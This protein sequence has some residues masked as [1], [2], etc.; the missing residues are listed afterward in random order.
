MAYC[1]CCVFNRRRTLRRP[2]YI[3]TAAVTGSVTLPGAWSGPCCASF[4][5]NRREPPSI[6]VQQHACPVVVILAVAAG[7]SKAGIHEPAQYRPQYH[8]AQYRPH[9]YPAGSR[10]GLLMPMEMAPTSFESMMSHQPRQYTHRPTPTALLPPP[11]R[12][13]LPLALP[14]CPSRLPPPRLSHQ[15]PPALPKGEASRGE[16]FISFHFCKSKPPKTPCSYRHQKHLA[17][18]ATMSTSTSTTFVD[19][20]GNQTPL[21]HVRSSQDGRSATCDGTLSK[22]YLALDPREIASGFLRQLTA[23]GIKGVDLF[24]EKGKDKYSLLITQ[25]AKNTPSF[26]AYIVPSCVYRH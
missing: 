3:C 6:K 23:G 9:Y 20:A 21:T 11:E 10:L 5:K 25:R 7:G 16:V 2:E 4:L 1:G 13:P 24:K 18:I 12:L 26:Y 14:A 22:L 8:P 19:T 17:L 15:G